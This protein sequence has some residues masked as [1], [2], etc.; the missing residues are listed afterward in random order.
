VYNAV[1]QRF[2]ISWLESLA[3]NGAA[4]Y[5]DRLPSRPVIPGVIDLCGV[6]TQGR[7]GTRLVESLQ[8]E[9]F[10]CIEDRTEQPRSR[11]AGKIEP[12]HMA[13]ASAS[14]SQR[15]GYLAAASLVAVQVG[16]GILLKT[17]QHHGRY[18]F[19]PSGSV[20]I[21]EFVKLLISSVLF[22]LEC[23]RRLAEGEHIVL[24]GPSNANGAVYTAV[25]DTADNEASPPSSRG[26]RALRRPAMSASLFWHYVQTDVT[27]HAKYGFANL[28]LLYMLI[29]NLVRRYLITYQLFYPGK[30]THLKRFSSAINWPIQRPFNCCGAA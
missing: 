28:S 14:A 2:F 6:P 4:T 3:R 7:S 18:E 15:A 9:A 26:D 22:Y 30:L 16:S 24:P 19:S 21:S 27:S 29:N 17:A 13:A 1:G 5:S 10:F 12:G 23:R 25:V 11:P 8:Q 20:A